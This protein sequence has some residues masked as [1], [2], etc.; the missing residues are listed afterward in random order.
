MLY[1]LTKT[2]WSTFVDH[3]PEANDLQPDVEIPEEENKDVA[4]GEEVEYCD[5]DETY[6]SENVKMSGTFFDR[7]ENPRIQIIRT[8]SCVGTDINLKNVPKV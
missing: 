3:I 5:I 8:D 4:E 6:D 2:D 7:N 1:Y